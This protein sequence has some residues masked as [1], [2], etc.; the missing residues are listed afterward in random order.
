[1]NR[2]LPWWV[3]SALVEK[4]RLKKSQTVLNKHG[5]EPQHRAFQQH[6]LVSGLSD[7][8]HTL[9]DELEKGNIV[10]KKGISKFTSD[11]VVFTGETE[12]T[13]VDFV[14][15]ATGFKQ[16]ASFVDPD[17][18]DFRYDRVGNDVP[19]Y[20]YIFPMHE[21]QY[22]SLGFINFLQSATFMCAE[23]QTRY[24]AQ[25]LKGERVLPPIETQREELL[26]VRNTLCAQYMDRQQ[27]RVQAGLTMKYYDDLARQIGCYPSLKAL[28]KERPT[29]IWHAWFTPWQ[30]LQYRLVGYGRL[31][32]SEEAIEQL[33]ESRFY[34]TCPR[35][36]K[37]RTG[38]KNRAGFIGFIATST[39]ISLI[40]G[41]LFWYWLKGASMGDDIQDKLQENLEYASSDSVPHAM[42]FGA[43][44][45]D[46]TILKAETTETA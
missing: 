17:I 16:A 21:N 12:A 41:L 19:L 23:L 31:E 37:Q 28:L 29:A 8:D 25:V 10:V 40:G 33:Y 14:I 45:Q 3:A 43:D 4:T 7:P 44:A 13:E 30:P 34:G 32:N 27:L 6:L 24:F 18:V 35:T 42:E 46:V 5:L 26:A 36:G 9:H 38:A 11:G 22:S 2:K 15:F 20:K 1:K 39:T